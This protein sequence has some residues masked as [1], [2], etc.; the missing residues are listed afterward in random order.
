MAMKMYPAFYKTLPLLEPHYQI[1][2]CHIEDTHSDMQLIYSEAQANLLEES[3]PFTEI[4]SVY[5]AS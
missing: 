1:V 4:Q 5:S 2:Y 3:Y